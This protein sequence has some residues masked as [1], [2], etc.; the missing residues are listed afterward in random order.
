MN[1]QSPDFQRGHIERR[2]TQL[3]AR[4]PLIVRSEVFALKVKLFLLSNKGST[5]TKSC[6]VLYQLQMLVEQQ[7]LL[8]V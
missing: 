3:V 5:L 6:A 7:R 4:Q 1:S 2:H 8:E